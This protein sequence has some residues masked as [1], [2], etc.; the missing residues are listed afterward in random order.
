MPAANG[1]GR[2]SYADGQLFLSPTWIH[3]VAEAVRTARQTDSYFRQ[4]TSGFTQRVAYLINDIPR[5]LSEHYGGGNC[6]VIQVQ[7]DKG[8]LRGI[9]IGAESPN[10]KVDLTVTCDYQVARQLFQG[11]LGPASA[12]LNRRFQIEPFRALYRK[13]QLAAK[14]IVAGNVVLRIARRVPTVFLPVR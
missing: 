8:V 13:P 12:F 9:R 5:E 6:V 2:A 7:L 1:K 4:L 14:S 3:T 10:G 11:E